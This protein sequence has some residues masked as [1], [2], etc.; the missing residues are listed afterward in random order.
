MNTAH[1]RRTFEVVLATLFSLSAIA[2]SSSL[3][4]MDADVRVAVPTQDLCARALNPE[5]ELKRLIQILYPEY[6]AEIVET[7]AAKLK[8]TAAN[9][10]IPDKPAHLAH[11]VSLFA[12]RLPYYIA[13]GKM[14]LSQLLRGFIDQPRLMAV[15]AEPTRRILRLL[16]LVQDRDLRHRYISSA[17]AACAI[18]FE[19][20]SSV[21]KNVPDEDDK[22]FAYRQLEKIPA[23]APFMSY[24]DLALLSQIPYAR[25]PGDIRAKLRTNWGVDLNQYPPLNTSD[26]QVVTGRVCKVAGTCPDMWKIFGLSLLS[27][28][29]ATSSSWPAFSIYDLSR[30]G[31]AGRVL[32]VYLSN[33]LVGAVKFEGD[34]SFIGLK[35]VMDQ[36][37]RLVIALGGVYWISKELYAHYVATE[38]GIGV[39]QKALVTTLDVSPRTFL[40]NHA[41]IEHGTVS[42][43]S[44]I[45]N[46]N[47]SETNLASLPPAERTQLWHALIRELD[48]IRQTFDP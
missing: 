30:D 42:I 27:Y 26:V 31:Y 36:N 22:L 12:E 21:I 5:A 19:D 24:Y 8:I 2:W 32:L 34:T 18:D 3:K 4:A 13:F 15:D 1:P 35:N 10:V 45:S 43:Q 28:R 7:V 38:D 14:D 47:F 40:M 17:I 23:A 46:R 25:I 41:A 11:T 48:T 37:G 39:W 16:S 9:T 29:D 6:T 33:V 20:A 44:R